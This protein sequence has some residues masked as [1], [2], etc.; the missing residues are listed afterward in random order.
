MKALGPWRLHIKP[1]VEK[2]G[3]FEFRW[4]AIEAACAGG[5]GI[6]AG[7]GQDRIIAVRLAIFEFPDKARSDRGTVLER[8]RAKAAHGAVA[9]TGFL[10]SYEVFGRNPAVFEECDA[11]CLGG[12]HCL[13]IDI[14]GLKNHWIE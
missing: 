3:P 7:A 8:L 4:N 10:R 12:G 14:R 2:S 1:S 6:A 11:K 5:V 13:A 9:V